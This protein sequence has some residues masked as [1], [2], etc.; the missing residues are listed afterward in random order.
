ML[1]T[2]SAESA[3]ILH[4]D[5]YHCKHG[6]AEAEELKLREHGGLHKKPAAPCINGSRKRRQTGIDVAA[7][8]LGDATKG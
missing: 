3:F 7:H 2:P 4:N 8:P 1:E 6:E 5:E